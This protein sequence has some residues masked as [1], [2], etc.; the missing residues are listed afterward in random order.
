MATSAPVT[1]FDPFSADYIRDPYPTLARMRAETPV[2]YAPKIGAYVVTRYSDVDAILMDAKTFSSA[3]PN[4]SFAPLC[5]EALDTFKNHIGPN[6]TAFCDPPKHTQ[7]RR[8]NMRVMSTRRLM[9][10]EPAI[11]AKAAVLID[12]FPRDEDADLVT[13]LAFPLPALTIYSLIGFPESDRDMLK[14]WATDR[15]AMMGGRPTRDEQIRITQHMAA[16]WKYCE[17]FVALRAGNRADDLTSDLLAASDAEPDT[18]SHRD[19]AAVLF[20]VSVAGHETTTNLILNLTRQLMLHRDQWDALVANPALIPG[21][22][23]EG[24][25]FDISAFTAFRTATVPV[26]IRGVEIPAGATIICMIAAANHD[27]DRFANAEQFEI[28]RKDHRYHL[29]FGRGIHLCLGNALARLEVRIVLEMLAAQFPAMEL[30]PGQTLTFPS[31]I[32]FRGPTSLRLRL[33]R[34][35]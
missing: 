34:A 14:G 7:V 1:D 28:Q 32:T 13:S 10:L 27:E 15:L 24:L 26:T 30:A 29:G 25:R 33:N 16:Y 35:A 8:H 19:I 2:A 4:F 9:M 23:E 31:N 6:V 17:T 22:V 12:A 5:A 11:R 18:L 20:S 3:R 21:A